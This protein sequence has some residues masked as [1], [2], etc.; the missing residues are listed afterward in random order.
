MEAIETVTGN[1]PKQCS[2]ST[3]ANIPLSLGIPAVTFGLYIGDKE[4]TREEFVEIDSLENGLRISLL[5]I[6]A[7]FE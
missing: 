7:H 3:D 4:H 2:A 5:M 1:F 6:T